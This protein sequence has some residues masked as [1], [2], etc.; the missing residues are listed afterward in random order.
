M[1][2][3]LPPLR[4]PLED[5][6]TYNVIL[7]EEPFVW[8]VSHITRRPVPSHI[9]RPK[10][11]VQNDPSIDHEQQYE[12][13]GRINLGSIDEKRVRAAATLA[14][15][16]RQYAGSLVQ[17]GVTTNS[18]DA[19]IHNFIIAH[20]AYPSPLLYKGFP[21]S[22]CTSVNNV[23]SHGIPDDRPL[24]DGDI[25]NIDVT[26]YLD[27][28]HGDTSSTF[29]VG[30]VDE[31]GRDLVHITN[32]A[33]EAGINCLRTWAIHEI[34]R[35]TCHSVCPAFAGHGIGTVFHRPPW[36]YH[37]LNEEPGVMLPGHCFTIEPSL[38]QG[39]NPSVWIFPDGWTASTENCA[40]SA[41]AEHMILITETGSRCFN[42]GD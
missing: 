40:R 30:D 39:S 8:G 32:T 29:L 3:L 11:A 28:Y 5:F 24:E 20:E 23:V 1:N 7:P 9:V 27:G 19:A 6:G 25:I 13:D 16:V 41:Q 31:P 26:I 37:T 21:R 38:V 33:L 36:I 14:K 12:G 42:A 34:V 2:K 15:N 22:C 35:N 4:S 18:I 17:P 10:Y